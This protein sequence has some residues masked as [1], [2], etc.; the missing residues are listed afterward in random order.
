MSTDK[1]ILEKLKKML[2]VSNSIAME[3]MRNILDIDKKEFD[4]KIVDWAEQFGFTID[5]EYVNVKKETVDDFIDMLDSE[6]KSWE[7]KEKI[8]EGKI[9]KRAKI[10]KVKIEP[11]E[12]AK[13]VV[14]FRGAQI[15]QFEAELLQEIETL[16]KK[17]FT[18]VDKLEY[19][20]KMGFLVENNR[21]KGIGLYKCRLSTLRE[22]ITQLKS[23][24]Y[25]NLNS[26][27]F[28]TLPESIIKLEK[29]ETLDL[30]GNQLST[31][32]ESIIN[33]T[34]LKELRLDSNQLMTLL[35]SVTKLEKL[36]TLDLGGNQLSTLP[37]SITQ[38]KSL[39]YLNLSSNKFITLP[40]SIGNLKS[41]QTLRLGGNKLSNLPEFIG[42]L[43]LN[44]KKKL[45]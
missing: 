35:E 14:S 1:A 34:S 26:N 30:G 45:K 24:T 22:S 41:L 5:R 31:L 10:E 23:L 36:E 20:T 28:T 19:D 40:E 38:L 43:K 16:T 42:N 37:E 12:E 13:K 27:K 9:V 11:D 33:L 2:K 21:V 44:I 8:G 18:K 6:F 15:M 4:K 17:K 3:Q 7:S 29:L 39:T 32:P 25:L